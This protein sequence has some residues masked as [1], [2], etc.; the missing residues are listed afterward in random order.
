MDPGAFLSIV[1]LLL[2]IV[3]LPIWPWTRG[4]SYRP[5]IVMGVM[6]TAIVV[7]WVTLLI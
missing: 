2:L 5:A 7:A 6:L 4:I 3:V 1:C